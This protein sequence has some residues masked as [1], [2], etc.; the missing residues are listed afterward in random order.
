MPF[1]SIKSV[2]IEQIA[3]MLI[4]SEASLIGTMGPVA[5]MVKPGAET[6]YGGKP[7]HA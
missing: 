6:H 1:T 3:V 4:E 7:G 5:I 2:L